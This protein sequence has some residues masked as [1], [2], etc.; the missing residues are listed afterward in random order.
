ME[1]VKPVYP[2]LG[3]TNE[4][5]AISIPAL[6]EF[7]STGFRGAEGFIRWATG[8]RSTLR[9]EVTDAM[10]TM[11]AKLGFIMSDAATRP[12]EITFQVNGKP[13]LTRTFAAEE[14]GII[15]LTFEG[16]SIQNNVDIQIDCDWREEEI[17]NNELLETPPRCL[18]VT[19]L[20]LLTK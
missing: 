9:F 20:E 11:G 6:D 16:F 5:T 17:W 18:G 7:L 3:L 1:Y 15:D 19:S 14:V 12:H 4:A 8:L 13:A 2:R 10:Q